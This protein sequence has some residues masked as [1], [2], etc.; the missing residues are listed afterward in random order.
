MKILLKE[1]LTLILI[2]NNKNKVINNYD[3]SYFKSE[4]KKLKSSPINMIIM[5]GSW[6]RMKPLSNIL[7]KALAP[8]QD[9]PIIQH[10]LKNLKTRN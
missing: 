5:A 1:G 9:K 6:Q 8:I 3:K 10:I 4:K 7:P 2:L